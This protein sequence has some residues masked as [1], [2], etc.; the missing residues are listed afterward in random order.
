MIIQ[1]EKASSPR[2]IGGKAPVLN[3]ELHAAFA[4]KNVRVDTRADGQRISAFDQQRQVLTPMLAAMASAATAIQDAATLNVANIATTVLERRIA[5][6]TS[7]L[8]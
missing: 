2:V 1:S 4:A 7:Q 6:M 5:I 3:D 8:Q